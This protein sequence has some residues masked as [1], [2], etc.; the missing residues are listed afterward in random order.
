M[1]LKCMAGHA[2]CLRTMHHWLLEL[3]RP[4]WPSVVC[5]SVGPASCQADPQSTLHT[6]PFCICAP[7]SFA[8]SLL[9]SAPSSPQLLF[10]RMPGAWASHPP[11]VPFAGVSVWSSFLSDTYRMVSHRRYLCC[12]VYRCW[13]PTANSGTCANWA[14]L[15]HAVCWNRQHRVQLSVI[16]SEPGSVIWDGVFWL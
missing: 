7:F 1:T 10:S 8:P 9:A 16:L 4:A 11:S 3:A 14:L 2:S 15:T 12:L 6:Q 5:A 13:A